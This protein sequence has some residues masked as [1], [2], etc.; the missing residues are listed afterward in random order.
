MNY[1][2]SVHAYSNLSLQAHLRQTGF[3]PGATIHLEAS[4]AQSGIPFSAGVQVKADVKR[5][6]GTETSL[7]LILQ[8]ENQFTASFATTS[9]GVYQIRIRAR[10][11]AIGGELFTREKTLTAAV[12]RGGDHNANQGNNGRII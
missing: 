8:G 4:L 11:T 6:D 7:I 2:L 1:C 9:P 5:P 10:G 3:E 12:W